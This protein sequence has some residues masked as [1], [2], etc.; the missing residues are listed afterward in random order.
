MGLYFSQGQNANQSETQ[1]VL[2]MI[3]TWIT[4]SISYDDN[5]Y[6]IHASNI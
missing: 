1:T 5:C 4:N 2:S 3:W 6:A